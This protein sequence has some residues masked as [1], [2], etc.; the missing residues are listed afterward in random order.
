MIPSSG[1]GAGACFTQPKSHSLADPRLKYQNR[2]GFEMPAEVKTP[3]AQ[4]GIQLLTEIRGLGCVTCALARARSTQPS[5][6]I[7]LHFCIW[8]GGGWAYWGRPNGERGGNRMTDSR[9]YRLGEKTRGACNGPFFQRSKMRGD[10]A[11]FRSSSS[12][13]QGGQTECIAGN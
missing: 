9:L 12:D 4:K 13:K 7:F 2:S 5:P 3:W 11:N 6:L 10:R 1:H 8:P